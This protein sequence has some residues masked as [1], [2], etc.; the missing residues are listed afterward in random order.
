MLGEGAGISDLSVSRLQKGQLKPLV[1]PRELPGRTM[2]EILLP[3]RAEKSSVL[4]L[5][6]LPRMR[7]PGA[8]RLT[9]PSLGSREGTAADLTALRGLC[10]W[11]AQTLRLVLLPQ[12]TW[13]PPGDE[14]N[15]G[16]VLGLRVRL[17]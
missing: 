10:L 6:F 7:L 11:S 3:L 12:A 9:L 1:G 2:L 15:P 8:L 5:I 17:T 13:E 4:R 16:Q 14:G